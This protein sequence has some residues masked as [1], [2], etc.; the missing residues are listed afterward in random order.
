M[1]LVEPEPKVIWI[2]PSRCHRVEQVLWKKAAP[3]NFKC[4]KVVY[5]PGG[6][7]LHLQALHFHCGSFLGF[8]TVGDAST[9]L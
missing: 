4:R 2:A 7:C 9:R 3:Y 8:L 1:E 5:L 6:C